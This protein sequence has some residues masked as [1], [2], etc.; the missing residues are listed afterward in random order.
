[1]RGYGVRRLLQGY[2][3][4]LVISE[5]EPSGSIRAEECLGQL[6]DCKL[7]MKNSA[8]WTYK[9]LESVCYTTIIYC[10]FKKIFVKLKL[11]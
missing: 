7:T 6:S 8:P 3:R 9:I 10:H 2:W 5:N 1:M 11:T 4:A